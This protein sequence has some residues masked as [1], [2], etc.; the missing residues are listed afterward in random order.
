MKNDSRSL[1]QN[2]LKFDIVGNETN[3][4]GTAAQHRFPGESRFRL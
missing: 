3:K 4:A 2:G 1:S